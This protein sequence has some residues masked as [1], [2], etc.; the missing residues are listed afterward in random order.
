ML[1]NR[2]NINPLSFC[3]NFISSSKIRIILVP[4]EN[5]RIY[6][7]HYYCI[8]LHLMLLVLVLSAKLLIKFCFGKHLPVFVSFIIYFC[9]LFLLFDFSNIL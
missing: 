2:Y 6:Y 8:N 3:K 9:L 4:E 5:N 7:Y 1:N